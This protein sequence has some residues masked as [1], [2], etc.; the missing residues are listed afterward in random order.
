[1]RR[2]PP[3]ALTGP[4]VLREFAALQATNGHKHIGP[5]E[6]I[7]EP[8]QQALVVVGSRL[9]IFLKDALGFANCFERQFLIGHNAISLQSV[10]SSNEIM[11]Q[12]VL[13]RSIGLGSPAIRWKL[14]E[15]S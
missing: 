10:S 9:K 4:P 15:R 2:G 7:N 14:V 5:I 6:H 8:A 3:P 11:S 1:M 13:F 12:V